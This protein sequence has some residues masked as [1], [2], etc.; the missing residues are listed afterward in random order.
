[1]TLSRRDILRAL[2]SIG[3]APQALALAACGDDAGGDDG[4]DTGIGGD[5]GIGGDTGT[6]TGG[7]TGSD[8]EDDLDR[9]EYDGT[10]GPEDLFQHGVAS[11]DPLADAVMLW[12]ALTPADEGEIEVW[13]EVS[14]N[15]AFTQRVATGTVLTNADR[16]YT[17]KLDA[18]GLEAG[19]TYYYRFFAL[20][21]EST[22]GRTRTAPTGAV[23]QLRIAVTSCASLGHGYFHAYRSLAQRRDVDVVLN[24]GDYIYEYGTNQYGNIREYEPANEI[25]TL[26]DYRTRYRQYR[27]DL[28]LQAAHQQ[29][30]WINVWDDHETADNSWRDGAEN[31]QGSEGEWADRKQAAIQAYY[32]WLPIREQSEFG[33]V[34]RAFQFG[35]LLDLIM[36]DTRLWGRDEQVSSTSDERF[37]EERQLLGSDQE[38]WAIEQ[39][40]NSSATWKLFGQ[41]VMMAHLKTTGLPE[42]EGGGTIFNSD[43]WDGYYGARERLF[44]VI[45]AGDIENV[46][47]LTGDIHSSWAFDLSKDPNNGDV[48]DPETGEGSLGVEFVCPG[49]TS[50]GFPV[51]TGDAFSLTFEQNNPHL[52]W[53]NLE[54]R[55]YLMLDVTPDGLQGTWFHQTDVTDP[56]YQ[57]DTASVT[58]RTAAGANHLVEEGSIL[59]E[60]ADY[61]EP[62]PMP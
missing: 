17:V 61:P 20:G 28:D 44:D 55:G 37:D 31:H 50:P 48:Y 12:T 41:Q 39:L 14:E 40:Q 3:L 6:D 22:T 38:D 45:E 25:V 2:A 35:D 26:E 51:G 62:A 23:D 24:L 43:Q 15:L 9:Y 42:S 32:E 21:R 5:A 53:T 56:T 59:P 27:R 49:I 33:R 60:R 46:V 1:M 29:A 30:P 52:R 34:W 11:G 10:P 58:L 4:A 18:T 7:D 54:Q 8:W 16:D 19:R 13:W 57:E 36:L 47:V